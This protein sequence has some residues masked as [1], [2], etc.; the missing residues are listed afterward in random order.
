M[1]KVTTIVLM[2]CLTLSGAFCHAS[3]MA[4]QENMK[5]NDGTPIEVISKTVYGGS[6]KGNSI[7]AM[8]NG[9][10]L[11]V[12]FTEN[13]GQVAV[14]VTTANGVLVDYNLVLTPNGMQ[15]YLPGA[16]DYIITFTLPNGDEYYGEFT[17][18]N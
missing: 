8:V 10:M 17:V 5:G 18:M 7:I 1:K 2:L 11:L 12:A 6:D 16:G 13:L 15:V 14:E 4:G 3:N 9:N